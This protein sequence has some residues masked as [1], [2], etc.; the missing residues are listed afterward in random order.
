MT[1]PAEEEEK[2]GKVDTLPGVVASL[3]ESPLVTNR[4]PRDTSPLSLLYLTALTDRDVNI[5]QDFP[6]PRPVS[7]TTPPV[8]AL[9]THYAHSPISLEDIMYSPSIAPNSAFGQ[10]FNLLG[11][12]PSQS[13]SRSPAMDIS[14]TSG[15]GVSS[16]LPIP[17]LSLLLAPSTPQSDTPAESPPLDYIQI[18]IR[19]PTPSFTSSQL[20]ELQSQRA[21]RVLHAEDVAWLLDILTMHRDERGLSTSRKQVQN[22]VD[23]ML[24]EGVEMTR[25][26]GVRTEAESEPTLLSDL[27]VASIVPTVHGHE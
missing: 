1:A 8:V 20:S 26:E 14:Y 2:E 21:R 25:L 15:F 6:V 19:P 24:L 3:G 11:T 5:R 18:S 27:D 9:D 13:Q 4:P 23:V 16:A 10:Y 12:S 7:M 17:E 22:G